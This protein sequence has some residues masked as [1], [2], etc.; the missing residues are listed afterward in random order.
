MIEVVL[1]TAALEITPEP[2][3]SNSTE[4]LP[5]AQISGVYPI[6]INSKPAA[7]DDVNWKYK[8]DDMIMIDVVMSDGTSFKFDVQDVSN[9]P[10]W[11]NDL[12]G[13]NQAI[14]D[15]NAWL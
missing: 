11:T 5:K 7:P 10:T 15:I 6:K 12:A 13:Q 4:L 9:Q 14:T 1:G 2:T 8:Y 3:A